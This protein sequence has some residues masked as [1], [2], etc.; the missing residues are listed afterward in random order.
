MKFST[1]IVGFYAIPAFL[2]VIGLVTSIG[3]LVNTQM[4][5]SHYIDSE[6]AIRQGLT[7][8]YAQGLQ[9]GQAL[10]NVV[11][12]PKNPKAMENFKA[13]Q[14]AYQKSFEQTQS[15]ATGTDLQAP[16]KKLPV[17]REV[18]EK[19]QVKVLTSGSTED[20]IV[21]LNKEETPAWRALR[22][23][24][25]EQSK[26]AET[27]SQSAH[28]RVNVKTTF[29]IRLSIAISV[30]AVLVAAG[31]SILIRTTLRRELGGDPADAREALANIADGKLTA[32]IENQGDEGSLMGAT[33]KMQSS[34]TKLVTDVRDSASGI[35]TATNE[36]A[37]GSQ[38]LSNRTESQAS[39]LEQ[40][41]A[42]MEELMSQVKKNADNAQLAN[43]LASN[44][45]TMAV[46]GGDVVG[47]VVE[48]M[49]G[50]NDSSRKIFEIISVIDGIAFQTN[51][52]ALNAAVEAARA[53]EQ[54]RGFAVVAS[55]VRAL[56]GRSADAAKEIKTLINAS[57]EKVEQGS[58]LVD[59]AGETMGE[60][61]TSIQKSTNLM[62]EIS[63]AS[64]EQANGVAQIGEAVTLMDQTTQQNAALVEQMAAAA[65]SLKSQ[66]GD[67]VQSV[68]LFKVDANPSMVR[69]NERSAVVLVNRGYQPPGLAHQS[70]LQSGAASSFAR[71][72]ASGAGI[73]LDN[74]IKAHADWRS[75]LRSAA[76]NHTQVDAETIKRDDCCEL[77][78]WLH[79]AGNS[80]FGGKPTF[81]AL[82]AGHRDF[83]AEAGKVARI[84]NQGDTAKAEQML[85]SG[86]AFAR[87]SGEVGRLI[88]QLKK[89][90]SGAS[91]T[92]TRKASSKMLTAAAPA[93][94]SN[95]DWETF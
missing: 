74:A 26:L 65:N 69:A 92:S 17:L 34:L 50:I 21:V 79:G 12:D 90:L 94:G 9:M 58:S 88:V 67:L 91:K 46:R 18:Q 60:L 43:E 87:A 89:E 52:L 44:A 13:A 37:A 28:E 8:M 75:K 35:A 38:D 23:E 48:T 85:E 61:V 55:E 11:L 57:V 25:L 82:I 30:F 29:A 22:T 80:K 86:T 51:I 24:L 63:S 27:L 41:A 59:Q 2:F 78:K 70:P 56:A 71:N 31:L 81:V 83:H 54:G 10:R 33:R 20:A 49:K 62:R 47:R 73:N 32:H 36:I 93:S 72:N 7:E 68:A 19:A 39:A 3:S 95:D 76:S 66:A 40:T 16:L 14:V 53:G 5:F 42:S 64:N 1:K 15:I 45:S 6:Q 77:G 84:V 4:E